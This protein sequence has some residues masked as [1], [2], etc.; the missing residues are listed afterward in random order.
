MQVKVELERSARVLDSETSML[1][2]H[3]DRLHLSSERTSGHVGVCS[4]LELAR[5]RNL[6]VKTA[7]L[8][9]ATQTEI[10][11]KWP[12]N[13]DLPKTR[14]CRRIGRQ[15]H[16]L[17]DALFAFPSSFIT[18]QYARLLNSAQASTEQ[19]NFCQMPS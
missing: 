13:S 7:D 17:R 8:T 1:V 12:E 19:V 18:F 2:Q 5:R 4:L 3:R 6:R 15:R 10:N 16:A 14:L 11:R 9:A